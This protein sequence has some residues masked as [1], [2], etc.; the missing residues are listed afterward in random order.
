MAEAARIELARVYGP[1]RFQDAFL[2]LPDY[3]HKIKIWVC[4]TAPERSITL[5]YHTT[6]YDFIVT[7]EIGG[8]DENRT[9][10]RLFAKQSRSLRTCQPINW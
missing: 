9:H 2:G 5:K 10:N 3:F 7:F 6:K 4:V 1:R 8:P